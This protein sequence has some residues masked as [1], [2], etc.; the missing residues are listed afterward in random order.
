MTDNKTA[1]VRMMRTVQGE[2]VSDNGEREIHVKGSVIEL[3]EGFASELV[4][5]KAAEFAPDDKLVEVPLH[6]APIGK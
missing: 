3:S 1:R 2:G 4:A 5:S 6:P